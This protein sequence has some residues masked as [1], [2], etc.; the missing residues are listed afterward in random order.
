MRSTRWYC[1]DRYSRVWRN[2]AENTILLSV[3][4]IKDYRHWLNRYIPS[5]WDSIFCAPQWITLPW[6][7]TVTATIDSIFYW[8]HIKRSPHFHVDR[9]ISP[10]IFYDIKREPFTASQLSTACATGP[11]AEM[12]YLCV[13]YLYFCKELDA[14]GHW[15]LWRSMTLVLEEI[16]ANRH[17]FQDAK[18][19]MTAWIRIILPHKRQSQS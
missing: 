11:L 1:N 8:Q 14:N 4:F 15:I 13:A 12:C 6:T 19:L 18:V 10:S 17:Y 3:T 5:G 16:P 7:I 9:T 2:N